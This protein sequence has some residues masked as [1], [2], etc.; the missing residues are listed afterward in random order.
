MCG[1][2]MCLHVCLSLGCLDDMCSWQHQE[3]PECER[4]RGEVRSFVATPLMAGHASVI[5]WSLEVGVQSGSCHSSEERSNVNF[6]R[7]SPFLPSP[8]RVLSAYT[9]AVKSNLNP[10]FPRNFSRLMT[11]FHGFLSTQKKREFSQQCF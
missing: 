9:T 11:K 8:S 2:C 3:C 5:G 7:S 6:H 1:T 4:R 10:F